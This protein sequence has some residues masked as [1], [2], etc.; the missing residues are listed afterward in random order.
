MLHAG[1][2]QASDKEDDHEGLARFGAWE[3]QEASAVARES[4]AKGRED[5]EE[6]MLRG[7]DEGQMP[8]RSLIQRG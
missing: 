7:A 1:G 8:W 5:L 2:D 6:N 4:R 3:S